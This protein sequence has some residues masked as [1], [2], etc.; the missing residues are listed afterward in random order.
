M[1]AA[2][3]AN[4]APTANAPTADNPYNVE[5]RRLLRLFG[6]KGV[7]AS[8]GNN[9]FPSG[10]ALTHLGEYCSPPGEVDLTISCGS[11][12]YTERLDT[13]SCFGINPNGDV[14]LCSISIG[15]IYESDI[16]DIVDRYNPYTNPAWKAVL[17]GSV[18]ELLRYTKSQNIKV[19]T[20]DCRSAC[21]VCRKIMTALKNAEI[22]I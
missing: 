15:N 18:T 14:N 11:M 16:I 8:N 2:V 21:G 17:D 20:S 4:I 5:T 19:A 1:L 3:D 7:K 13:V 12:P 6:D 10:N 22:R 9:V